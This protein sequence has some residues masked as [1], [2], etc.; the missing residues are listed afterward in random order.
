MGVVDTFSTTS[1]A[2]GAS[3]ALTV[4]RAVS[5]GSSIVLSTARNDNSGSAVG[6]ASITDSRSNTWALTDAAGMRAGNEEVVISHA[7]LTT[8]LQVGDTITVTWNATSLGRHLIIAHVATGLNTGVGAEATS[9]TT[10]T[11]NTSTGANGVGATVTASTTGSTTT[12]QCLVVAATAA[13]NQAAPPFTAASGYTAG[14]TVQTSSGAND[15]SLA[16]EYK[17]TSA[18]GVQTAGGSWS[19][20]TAWAEA[21]A[22]YPLAS[23]VPTVDAGPDQ[24]HYGGELVVLQATVTGTT[25]GGSWSQVSGTAVTLTSINSTTSSFVA[26]LN[27]ASDRVRVFRYTATYTGGSVPDDVQ[28]TVAASSV[29]SATGGAYVAGQGY[30]A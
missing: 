12:A 1:T 20:S 26:D 21:V 29:L 2:T 14:P 10:L 8:G 16:T 15:R 5:A 23:A 18:A 11:L 4:P 28:V 24:V 19:T 6:L 9:G 7:H 30:T 25:T 22:A 13:T 17:T 3:L 27:N